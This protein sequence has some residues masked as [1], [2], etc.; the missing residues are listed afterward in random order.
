MKRQEIKEKLKN[1]KRH[2]DIDDMY[3]GSEIKQIDI[4]LGEM[5]NG[6]P[7]KNILMIE[8]LPEAVELIIQPEIDS[9]LV[10]CS[11]KYEEIKYFEVIK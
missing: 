7:Y 3:D 11:H 8:T 1:I 9:D 5:I 4:K 2:D 6:F 10:V